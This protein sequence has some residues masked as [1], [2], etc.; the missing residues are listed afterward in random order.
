MAGFDPSAEAMHDRRT[1][2]LLTVVNDTNACPSQKMR[3]STLRFMLARASWSAPR[4]STGSAA[5]FTGRG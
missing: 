4:E 1:N 2:R 5:V 3:A